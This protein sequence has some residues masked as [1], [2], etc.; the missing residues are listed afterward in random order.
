MLSD[1]RPHVG[2]RI[3]AARR[4]AGLTQV[5]LAAMIGLSQSHTSRLELSAN[6]R[7]STI[8]RVAEALAVPFEQLKPCAPSGDPNR[9]AN[10]PD[11]NTYALPC[12]EV[13]SYMRASVWRRPAPYRPSA[14]VAISRLS[15]SAETRPAIGAT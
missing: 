5:Q 7:D 3:R 8:R 6:P 2:E 9:A 14:M 15:F 12:G 10:G 1:D 11:C 13:P 4:A